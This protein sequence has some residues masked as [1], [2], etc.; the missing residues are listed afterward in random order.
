MKSYGVTIQMK[1][2]SRFFHM[3]L[4]VLCSGNQ[5]YGHLGNTVTLLFRQ[6]FFGPAK[7]SYIIFKRDF[8][9][10]KKNLGNADTR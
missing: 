5:P 3:I 8:I 7:R 1:P 4:F 2:L 10:K 6:L 9:K